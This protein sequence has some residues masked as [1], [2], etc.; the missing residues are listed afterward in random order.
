MTRYD[1]TRMTPNEMKSLAKE[2]YESGEI[3]LTQ[4]R[5]LDLMG[6]PRGQ[7]PGRRARSLDRAGTRFL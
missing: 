4:L 7:K 1:F 5:T 2:L 6:K 3:D